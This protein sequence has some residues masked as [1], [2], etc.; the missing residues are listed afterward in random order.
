MNKPELKFKMSFDEMAAVFAHEHPEF[1][2]NKSNV[3]RFARK[4]GFKPVKQVVD[5][6]Q[7]YSYYNPEL[8][9]NG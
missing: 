6:K 7:T 8:R 5:Y 1:I 3:G 9:N 2:P 4:I